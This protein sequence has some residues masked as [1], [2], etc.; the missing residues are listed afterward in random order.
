MKRNGLILLA[1]FSLAASAAVAAPPTSMVCA[2]GRVTVCSI[3]GCK[4]GSIEGLGVPGMIRLDFNTG[5]MLAV[6]PEDAG[7]KSTFKVLERNEDRIVLQGF[8][9]NRAFSAVIDTFG[10]A[11]IASSTDGR[12]ITMFGRCSDVALVTSGMDQAAP[13]KK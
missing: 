7:R 10:I 4:E 12:A 9:N 11:S 13:A 8:E 5:E 1:L 3:D 6:T 2:L